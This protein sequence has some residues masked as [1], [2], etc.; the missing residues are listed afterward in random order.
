VQWSPDGQT[1]YW[2][3]M[4]GPAAVYRATA[5]GGGLSKLTSFPLFGALSP[6]L[7][8][9]VYVEYPADF[10]SGSLYISEVDGSS[11]RVVDSRPAVNGAVPNYRF[12]W[13]PSH[14]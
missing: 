12:A 11:P 13:L 10:S 9:V 8:S 7:R 3:D 2:I 1:L 6:D 4:G 5:D 14:P